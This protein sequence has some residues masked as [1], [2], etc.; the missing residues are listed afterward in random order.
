VAVVSIGR[1][2]FLKYNKPQEYERVLACVT[3]IILS[4]RSMRAVL[5]TMPPA[6]NDSE[7]VRE[8]AAAVR[9]VA[10]ARGV[11]V[12]DLYSGFMGMGPGFQTLGPG[13]S[14]L[15]DAG[16]KFASQVTARVIVQGYRTPDND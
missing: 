2:H 16:L 1:D 4:R 15:S 10:D 3:D 7:A 6:G 12:A 14:E 11:P 5:V 8:Y 9:K 13:G